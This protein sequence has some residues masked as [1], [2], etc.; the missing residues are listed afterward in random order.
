M[1]KAERPTT[2]CRFCK[3]SVRTD[4]LDSH[5]R[6]VH[7]KGVVAC[8]VCQLLVA[9]SGLRR[10]IER[11]HDS[12]KV[13]DLYNYKR[14]VKVY[15]SQEK[16]DSEAFIEDLKNQCSMQDT[17]S[18]SEKSLEGL[19]EKI[20]EDIEKFGYPDKDNSEYSIY[21]LSQARE[22]SDSEA[23]T[24]TIVLIT[25]TRK[26]ALRNPSPSDLKNWMQEFNRWV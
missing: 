7:K 16:E 21:A 20:E 2:K 22:N 11:T 19:K 8:P 26:V 3:V 15:L 5:I 6:K 17:C 1:E 18:V 12:L 9:R 13:R 14:D 24:D 4:R 25:Q 10:H 23:D